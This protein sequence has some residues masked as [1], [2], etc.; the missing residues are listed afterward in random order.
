MLALQIVV[1]DQQT[2]SYSSFNMFGSL[3]VKVYDNFVNICP[4]IEGVMSFTY[5]RSFQRIYDIAGDC[6]S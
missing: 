4:E 6:G 1:R 5:Y 3:L 2:L